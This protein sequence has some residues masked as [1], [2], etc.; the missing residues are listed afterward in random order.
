MWINICQEEQ[1]DLKRYEYVPLRQYPVDYDF[2]KEMHQICKIAKHL[3]RD[4]ST[5]IVG[6]TYTV[7][8]ANNS[9]I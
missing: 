6:N 3:I 8:L 9:G 2:K 4:W 5:S 7:Y 1:K